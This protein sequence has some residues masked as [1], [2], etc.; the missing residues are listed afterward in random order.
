MILQ[1]SLLLKLILA[2]KV[3]LSAGL[4]NLCQLFA[5]AGAARVL[6]AFKQSTVLTKNRNLEPKF[7]VHSGFVEQQREC[8]FDM[9][10]RFLAVFFG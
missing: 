7:L 8:S 6:R 2:D 4:L 10:N 9:L 1:G 3:Y 5:S